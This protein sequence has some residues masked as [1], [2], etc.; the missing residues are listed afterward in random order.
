MPQTGD[1]S[2]QEGTF[3]LDWYDSDK[4]NVLYKPILVLFSEQKKME[5]CN[6]AFKKPA[7]D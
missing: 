2:T 1:Y 4:L 5:G 3:G 6:N 7:D